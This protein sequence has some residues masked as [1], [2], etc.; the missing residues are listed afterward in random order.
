MIVTT[1]TNPQGL[2]ITRFQKDGLATDYVAS[3]LVSN[4]SVPNPQRIQQQLEHQFLPQGGLCSRNSGQIMLKE[5]GSELDNSQAEE[6]E[7][8]VCYNLQVMELSRHSS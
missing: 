7:V 4:L 2:W 6:S 3:L 8:L 1:E 5:K